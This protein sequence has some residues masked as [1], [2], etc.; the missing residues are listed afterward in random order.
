MTANTRSDESGIDLDDIGTNPTANPSFTDLIASRLSRRHLFGLGVGTAGTALLQACGGGGGGGTSFPI[1]P[2]APAPAPPAPT[3]APPAQQAPLKLNFNAV[4]KSLDDVVTVPAGYT[5]SVLYRLGDPIAAG[6]P[7]YANDGTDAPS[8]Y[9]RRAGDHHDGMTFFGI[10]ASNKWDPAGASRGLLVMN[11]EAITPLFLH[12]AGQTVVGG[13]RTVADEVLREFY[14]HGVSVIEVNKVGNTWTY[15]QDSSLN[16]R[17]HTLTEMAFSGPA[18]KTDYLKTKYSTDGSKTRG[19]LNNCA[20]GT[21]PWGTYLTCEENWAGYFRRIAANDDKNRN[22]K[23][24]ASF[25]RYGVASTGRELWATVTPDTADDLYGRWNTEVIGATATDD[26]RNG[27]NTYG[28]VVEIDPFT[29]SSMPKKRTALGRFGH[30]GACLGPVVV[31]KPLVWYMGDDSRNEYIYKFVSTKNWDAADIGGGIASGDKYMDDGRLYVARFNEDGT[32][33]WLELKLGVNNITSS[34]D[35]YAFADAA[36]VVTNARLA[37]DA[38]GATKMDRP[39]WTAVNPKTGDVYVTLTNTNAA[40]RPITKTS[41]SNPRY[42]DDKTT[43][44]KSQLGNPN[45]HIVRFADDNADPTALG[46]KWDVY[47]FAA[48][49]TA[50]ADVNLSQLTADNDMSS[51]DGMWF[52]H[53]APGLLWLQTDDGAYTDVTNCMLLAA[54]PGK[55]GDGG[56]KVI[57]NVDAGTPR[58]QNT[59]V[60]KAPGTEGLRRFLVGPKDCE[61]TGIAESGDGRALFVNIQHP[62]EG[63]S[64]IKA[65]IS[66]WPDGGTS[67]PRSATVVITK[68]DG[69]LI[70]L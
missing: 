20:N 58:T 53:A 9:D 68:N 62:G 37:A 17:V 12:P 69:G 13:V 28:W 1:L 15:K 55:V 49:S 7:A 61:L 51:P 4:A 47:L 64:D 2:P 23:E 39:E 16:R 36:D 31:G 3:P 60:G 46:F 10:N 27:H 57:T 6:V 14:L 8:T 66:H 26:Y 42:Y 56:A 19:T 40:S 65:P 52:S 59:F 22:T 45:G 41:A 43:G 21:T 48:R 67:R 70:G 33:V 24:K 29:P 18:A 54:L 50:S 34:Y 5:A 25:S 38:A 63:T 32:G 11:H 44:G 35:K 30:E